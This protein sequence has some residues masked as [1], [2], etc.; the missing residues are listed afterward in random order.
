MT[1][2]LNFATD[3]YPIFAAAG[4]GNSNCHGG[5][6]PSQGLNLSSATV[7]QSMLVG[8][9]ASQCGERTRVVPGAPNSSYLINKLTGVD[10]CGGQRMPRGGTPLSNTQMDT[11]RAWITGL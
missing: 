7:A 3:V 1:A 8:V 4:C 5:G 11:I 6:A 10:M 2:A 9:A